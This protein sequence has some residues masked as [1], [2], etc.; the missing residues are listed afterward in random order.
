MYVNICLYKNDYFLLVICKLSNFLLGILK[1][2]NF[3]IYVLNCNKHYKRV[4]YLYNTKFFVISGFCYTYLITYPFWNFEHGKGLENTEN[5]LRT[6]IVKKRSSIVT[7]DFRIMSTL[8]EVITN[9][10]IIDVVPCSTF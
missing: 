5:L 1:L 7:R 8:V 9:Q 10:I 2:F 4:T 6:N 3:N